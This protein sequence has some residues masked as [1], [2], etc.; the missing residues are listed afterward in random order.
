MEVGDFFESFVCCFIFKNFPLK[1][2]YLNF[3]PNSAFLSWFF[4]EKWV[5]TFQ[6]EVFWN[7]PEHK[8]FKEIFNH[9]NTYFSTLTKPYLTRL[10]S[11]D[12]L[13]R[14]SLYFHI[15]RF[16]ASFLFSF[17]LT[18]ERK[19]IRQN[20]IF[21]VKKVLNRQRIFSDFKLNYSNSTDF[22]CVCLWPGR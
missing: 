1:E 8:V 5:K 11:Y 14:R 6:L 20:V 13:G 9:Y 17:Q 2:T 18:S 21:I 16:F 15:F 3:L 10:N 7:E 4:F 19:M 12:E 22:R